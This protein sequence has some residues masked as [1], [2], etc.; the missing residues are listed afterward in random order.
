MSQSGP[1]IARARARGVMLRYRRVPAEASR[2]WRLPTSAPV[3]DIRDRQHAGLT[4]PRRLVVAMPQP[5]RT[6]IYW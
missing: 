4:K 1:G 6:D 5:R 2:G 3:A